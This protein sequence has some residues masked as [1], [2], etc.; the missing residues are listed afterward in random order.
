MRLAKG[1]DSPAMYSVRYAHFIRQERDSMYNE[2]E[3]AFIESTRMKV[4]IA[5]PID[6]T[7]NGQAFKINHQDYVGFLFGA[8]TFNKHP[9]VEVHT[10]H[11]T[12]TI[13]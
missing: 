12:F 8:F 6:V 5:I 4:Y 3:H 2:A 10:K 11:G 1:F 13:N 7:V 9:R